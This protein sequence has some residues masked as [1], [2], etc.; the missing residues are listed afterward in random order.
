M[1]K[2]ITYLKISLNPNKK[3]PLDDIKEQMV[4]NVTKR[5]QFFKNNKKL[6]DVKKIEEY[7]VGYIQEEQIESFN[8]FLLNESATEP[9]SLENGDFLSFTIVTYGKNQHLFYAMSFTKSFKKKTG[10][11][12]EIQNITNTDQD[13]REHFPK[14]VLFENGIVYYREKNGPII[15]N[16]YQSNGGIAL[17]ATVW[18]F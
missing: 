14:M 8:D 15:D 9:F 6:S 12:K 11:F 4:S 7:Y 18:K 3:T 2:L 10:F 1:K 13:L 17:S 16:I 5:L